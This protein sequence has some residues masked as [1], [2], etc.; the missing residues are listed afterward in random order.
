ALEH[1]H[2]ALVAQ[3]RV[4]EQ[5]V[6]ALRTANP[7]LRQPAPLPTDSIPLA[8]T[9][10][11]GQAGAR[12]AIL[13]Y[14]DF[15][16]PYCGAF[17]RQTLPVLEERYVATGLVRLGFWQFPLVEIHPQAMATAG[18]AECAGQQDRFWDMHDA[19]FADQGRLGL[20]S[21]LSR[22]RDLELDESA[23]AECVQREGP[24]IAR[25]LS[26]SARA[27]GLSVTPTFIIG[28]IQDDGTLKPRQILTGARDVSAFAALIDPLI[29]ELAERHG[30][31]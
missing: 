14:S 16:C 25:Q 13:E 26:A 15:Q 5:H 18:A 22:A 17:A 29:A 8:P 23:F 9:H 28:L 24:E 19:L 12:I 4:L 11:A 27:L 20:A 6:G 1:A 3:I 2:A 30:Q 31:P 21:L 7:P 10:L